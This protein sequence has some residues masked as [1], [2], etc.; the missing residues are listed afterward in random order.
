M[1]LDP[2]PLAVRQDAAGS[3]EIRLAVPA[4][5]PCFADHF[6]D[7]PMLPGV[8]QVGWAVRLAQQHFGIAAPLHEARQLKF[9][10][11]IQPDVALTLTLSRSGEHDVAF[12]YATP[13]RL[14]SAGR[15]GFAA[16]A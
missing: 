7:H 9:Q 11:P 10:H 13:E 6:P 8:L 5:L 4:T 3:V 15:L 16:G 1:N 12:R 14:C 2:Q